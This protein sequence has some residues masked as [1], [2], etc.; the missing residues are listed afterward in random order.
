MNS[1]QQHLLLLFFSANVAAATFPLP[2]PQDALIGHMQYAT[3]HEEDTLLSIGRK[4]GIGYQQVIAANPNVDVWLPT[5]GLRVVIPSVYLLPNAPRYGI[6]INL[7]EQRLYFYPKPAAGQP[8]TVETFPISVGKAQWGT[9]LGKTRVIEKQMH[10]TWYPTESVR[11]EHADRG[12][13]LPKA[14]LP[15]PNNPL[16]DYALRLDIAGGAYLIHGTNKPIAIGMAVTHGC[17]RM[18]PEDIALL[19]EEVAVGTQVTLINQPYTMGWLGQQLYVQRHEVDQQRT[20]TVAHNLM[21]LTSLYVT[22]TQ[23]RSVKMDWHDAEQ[24]FTKASAIPV[25]IRLLQ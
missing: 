8:P 9:P 16:G 13:T 5:V 24:Q 21:A 4:Y 22:A 7:A 19:F 6:V 14:V 3:V 15:G 25:Q 11:K 12:E 2:S 20:K 23:H 17:I 1:T 18:L 10:P